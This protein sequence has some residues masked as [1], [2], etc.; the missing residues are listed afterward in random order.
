M[1]Q[2]ER[3]NKVHV[4]AGKKKR[5]IGTNIVE[6]IYVCQKT[7]QVLINHQEKEIENERERENESEREKKKQ[8]WRMRGDRT[9][10]KKK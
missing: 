1:R 6:M 3:E 7:I 10:L 8:T 9:E 2:T 5:K 4:R